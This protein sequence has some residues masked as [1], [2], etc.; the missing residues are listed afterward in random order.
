MKGYLSRYWEGSAEKSDVASD[1]ENANSPGIMAS[2]YSMAKDA[3]TSP[4]GQEAIKFMLGFLPGGGPAVRAFET[5]TKIA[6]MA[7][8]TEDVADKIKIG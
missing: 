3:A 4:I 7:D 6:K 2:T 5:G 1:D 8:S